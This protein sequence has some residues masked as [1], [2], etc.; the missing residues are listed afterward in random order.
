MNALVQTFKKFSKVI[1]GGIVVA[2]LM[3]AYNWLYLQPK[4][5]E[6]ADYI[7]G[8]NQSITSSEIGRE[9]ISTLNRLRTITI[10][11]DFFQDER[12]VRLEDFSVEIDPQ[13]VGNPNP[14]LQVDI[15]NLSRN[16]GEV[17]GADVLEDVEETD[18][19]QN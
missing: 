12:Y 9:I 13:P 16:G 1:F 6:E 4:K 18:Q 3:F 5:A 7:R 14:F 11:P 15:L 10:D 8:E 19:A 17:R 2:G